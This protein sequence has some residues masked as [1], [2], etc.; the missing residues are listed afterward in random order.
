M[1]NIFI[2][3]N[4]EEDEFRLRAVPLSKVTVARAGDDVV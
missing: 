4:R 2:D 1:H 3:L